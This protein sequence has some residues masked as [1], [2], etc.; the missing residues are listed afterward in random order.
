MRP[1][2]R[3]KACPSA[4]HIYPTR[5]RCSRIFFSSSLVMNKKSESLNKQSESGRPS[6]PGEGWLHS[7]VLLVNRSDGLLSVISR[8]KDLLYRIPDFIRFIKIKYIKPIFFPF[9]YGN[10]KQTPF[11]N[12]SKKRRKRFGRWTLNHDQKDLIQSNWPDR[13]RG[14]RTKTDTDGHTLQP[15]IYSGI[16]GWSKL[17]VWVGSS[18]QKVTP[19]LCS[20]LRKER[21]L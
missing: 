15:W 1:S 11:W 16:C 19:Y 7:D 18:I 17:A 12:N 21:A 6:I 4:R 10:I 2:V 20:N 5:G 8:G 14:E 3:W 9:L 13:R